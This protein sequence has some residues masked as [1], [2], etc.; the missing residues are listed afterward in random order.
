MK[1]KRAD[2]SALIIIWDILHNVFNFTPKDFTE[3]FD[4]MGADTF[5]SLQAC[6]LSGADIILLYKCVL[7][8]AFLFHNIPEV[9]I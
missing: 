7:R 5:V 4:S 9:I 8:N 3:N 2:F 1:E 6:N